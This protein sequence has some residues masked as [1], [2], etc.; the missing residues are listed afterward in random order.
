MHGL[1]PSAIFQFGDF[2]LDR[3]GG[4][5]F[6]C[7]GAGT[8]ELVAIGSRALDILG[9]LIER[10][11]EV[12]SKDE[13][14]AAVWPATA[15]EDS[16]LTVQISALRRVLDR[17]RSNGSCIQ[18]VSGRGHRFAARVTRCGTDPFPAVGGNGEDRSAGAPPVSRLPTAAGAR[19]KS[20]RL[21]AALF[22]VIAV[23]GSLAA[24][25]WDHRWFGSSD[26][27]PRFSMAVLPFSNLGP[28]PGQ[29]QF[30]DAIT[31][32]LTTALAQIGHSFVISRNTAFT[33]RNKSLDTKQIGAET[34][35]LLWA[36]PFDGDVG[37]LFA[38][39]DDITRRIGI[40]LC[41]SPG[42]CSAAL[43]CGGD[44]GG[45]PSSRRRFAFSFACSAT[46]LTAWSRSEA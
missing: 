17:G 11:D 33:C 32:D 5:L 42:Q 36:Q 30:V 18:T 2:R 24:W 14:I 40:E 4:G 1:A 23:A 35:A 12:V 31:S 7:N 10:A 16:N 45:W 41:R 21:I 27:R 8:F 22:V 19:Q 13:I 34:D 9:V 20:W 43:C 39:E 46:C 38:L 44:R 37:D 28:D 15:V 25:I 3:R 29:E 26:T 6:R